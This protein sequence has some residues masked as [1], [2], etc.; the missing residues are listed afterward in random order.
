M[1]I[2][3]SNTADVSAMLDADMYLDYQSDPD[4]TQE[5]NLNEILEEIENDYKDDECYKILKKA[6]EENPSLGEYTMVSQS[7]YE[8]EANGQDF[9]NY[10]GEECTDDPIQACAFKSPDGDLYVAYRGTG[11]KR[12]GDNGQGFVDESTDMQE[13]AKAYFDHVV[14]T[15]GYDGKGNVMKKC[16]LLLETVLILIGLAGCSMT[17][18]RYDPYGVV[19]YLE[20]K[21]DDEV[22][23]FKSYANTKENP[24]KVYQCVSKKNYPGEKILVIYDTRAD[25]YWDSYFDIKYAHQVDELI[26]SILSEVFGDDP[27]YFIHYEGEGISGLTEQ[28]DADTT[29]EEYIADKNHNLTAYIKS[30][31]SNEEVESKIEEQILN[32]GMYCR[33]ICLH[34]VED[35]DE[36]RLDDDS[37]L[38]DLNVSAVRHYV[39][40]MKDNKTFRESYW[41]D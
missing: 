36:Q 30:D 11:A 34:F 35:F 5:N 1:A 9:F 16:I 26:D 18:E 37:Y 6:C 32:S 19:E 31:K 24:R 21:Y 25:A 7:H 39:A 10:T 29:F 27:Y 22:R 15:Y 14:D 38:Y 28:Y 4:I 41:E 17:K 33:N 3:D 12:W 8:H 2:F 20:N 40:I 13:A 23:Y